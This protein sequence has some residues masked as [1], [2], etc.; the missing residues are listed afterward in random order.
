MAIKK[1]I[2]FLFGAAI[3]LAL[4][5]GIYNF[6]R[7]SNREYD[8]WNSGV[9][10][11]QFRNEVLASTNLAYLLK[12]LGYASQDH[13]VP[14]AAYS[15]YVWSPADIAF[16]RLLQLDTNYHTMLGE[17]LISLDQR[18]LLRSMLLARVI[19]QKY[20]ER[21]LADAQRH[22]KSE[23]DFKMRERFVMC[24]W[25]AIL[26]QMAMS[27]YG[28]SNQEDNSSSQTSIGFILWVRQENILPPCFARSIYLQSQEGV[29]YVTNVLVKSREYIDSAL[30]MLAE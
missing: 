17:F 21:F 1:C 16:V 12:I 29:W 19:Y 26:R 30:D 20:G 25:E 6:S 13:L 7:Q 15:G 22:I 27:S 2:L 5:L 14:G 18:N 9:I 3:P 11:T 4:Y 8:V 23:R 10:D 28:T 24:I